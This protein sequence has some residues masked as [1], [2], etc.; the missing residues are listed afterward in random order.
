[1]SSLKK[2]PDMIIAGIETSCDETSVGIVDESRILVNLIASQENIHMKFG[3]IVP[4]LASRAH[5]EK[6]VPLFQ[7]SLKKAGIN[8]DQIDAFGV[9]NS[10]GLKGSLLVGVAFAESIGYALK[11]PVYNICHLHAHIAACYLDAE[12]TFPALG[13]VISGGHTS[14]FLLK[15]HTRFFSVGKTRDDAC[16][17]AFDKVGRMLNL[18]FP[19]GANVEKLAEKGNENSIKIPESYI[20][21]SLD[22]SF[23]GIK[24][25][26]Y[27]Y[28]LK[29]GLKNTQD[30][31]AS[32]QRA[33]ANSILAKI[34]DALMLYP[35]KYFLFGGGVLR[36]NYVKKRIKEHL[37]NRKVKAIIP[38][39]DLCV[40]NGVMVA[41]LT[42]YLILDG[43]KP[44]P[45][46]IYVI[47]TR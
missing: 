17:E 30:I 14:L 4:E 31:A 33:I 43:Y 41:I 45:Y 2:E 46:R 12:I 9:T 47:P 21:N 1:M 26:V 16:G 29:N 6:I 15:S 19:G 25:A 39:P 34:D 7:K 22:F 37:A 38:A 36:N 24:T 11:K 18:P 8:P 13:L 5:L 27:Y 32:F 23:S 28:I 35:V 3:G 40:D 44:Q 20:K 10:P 42:K